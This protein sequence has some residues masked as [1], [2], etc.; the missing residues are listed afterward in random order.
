[1]VRTQDLLAIVG[2]LA[3]SFPSAIAQHIPSGAASSYV[4]PSGFPTS[5]FSSYWTKPVAT[6]E[7]QPAI[8]DPVLNETFPYNLTNPKTIPTEDDD[9][10]Y[11]PVPI[12]KLSISQQQ[13]IINQSVVEIAAIIKNTSISSNCTKCMNSLAVAKR[14]AQ[15]APTLVPNMAVEL[16]EAYKFHSNSTCEEDFEASTFGAVWTQVLYFAN[17]TGYDGQYICN[18]LSTTLC[19][20]PGVTPLD[21]TKLFPK[22]KPKNA[23]APKA[24]GKRV[25]VLHMYVL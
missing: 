1:M 20:A 18:S 25:K 4:A 10:V 3:L 21:N 11:Y 22:P 24:S 13:A 6:Q 7:P 16:C 8:Y 14:A 19:P 5:V 2:A 9:P 17:V 23:K 15:L 12:Q